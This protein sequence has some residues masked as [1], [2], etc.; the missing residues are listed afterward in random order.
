MDSQRQQKFA[1]LIMRELSEIFQKD[2]AVAPLG[3]LMTVSHVK[4]SADLGVATCYLS[5]FNIADPLAVMND[6]EDANSQVRGLLGN[7]IRSQARIIPELRFFKDNT[8]EEAQRIE[9]L[10]ASLNIPPAPGG[11][12]ESGVK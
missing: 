9:E 8:A 12:S 6:L 1:R 3:G 10:L 7:R 2:I 4:V 5:F 11:T